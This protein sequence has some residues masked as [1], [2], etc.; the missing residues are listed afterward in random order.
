MLCAE[1]ELDGHVQR[2]MGAI[3]EKGLVI[4]PE[5][6]PEDVIRLALR[7]VPGMLDVVRG[8]ADGEQ[9]GDASNGGEEDAEEVGEGEDNGG[10]EE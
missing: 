4:P 10:G 5:A 3:A 8:L 6:K 7:A 9:A 2:V 1:R